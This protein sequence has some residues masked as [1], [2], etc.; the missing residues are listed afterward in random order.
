MENVPSLD[1]LYIEKGEE[2]TTELFMF[3][4]GVQR[5]PSASTAEEFSPQDRGRLLRLLRSFGKACAPRTA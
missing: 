1:C 4:P 5:P 3:V 2:N